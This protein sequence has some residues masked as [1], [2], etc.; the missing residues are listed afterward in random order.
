VKCYLYISSDHAQSCL[1]RQVFVI[2]SAPLAS[3]HI[4]LSPKSPPSPS[5]TLSIFDGNHVDYVGATG[6]SIETVS[7]LHENGRA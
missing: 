6:S 7:H 1:R 2:A 3:D 5:L 4:N